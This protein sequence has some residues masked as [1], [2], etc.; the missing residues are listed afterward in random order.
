MYSCRYPKSNLGSSHWS[1]AIVLIQYNR[2]RTTRV[3]ALLATCLSGSFT[4]YQTDALV[5][6]DRWPWYHSF[7]LPTMFDHGWR[8]YDRVVWPWYITL[9]P[10]YSVTICEQ[11]TRVVYRQGCGSQ[12]LKQ[13]HLSLQ[14]S[15]FHNQSLLVACVQRS[16]L[17]Q[18]KSIFP[19]EGGR[20]YTGYSSC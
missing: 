17:T 2:Q 18:E 4:D 6:T 8:W 11:K 20:L 9:Q 3:L 16:P 15:G 12:H 1:H 14:F 19:K 7:L 5:N 10:I 13:H